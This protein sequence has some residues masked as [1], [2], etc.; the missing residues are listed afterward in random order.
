MKLVDDFLTYDSLLF[1]SKI[2]NTCRCYSSWG[3]D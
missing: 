1:V 2:Y 3:A